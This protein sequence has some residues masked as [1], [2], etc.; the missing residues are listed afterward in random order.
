M[1]NKEYEMNELEWKQHSKYLNVWLRADGKVRRLIY[2]G[3]KR[4]EIVEDYGTPHNGYCE[5]GIPGTTKLECVHRLVADVFIPKT[6]EDIELCRDFINHIDENR[7]NNCVS[8][9]EWCTNQENQ[10]HS[11]HK[12]RGSKCYRARIIERYDLLTGETIQVYHGGYREMVA[13]GFNSSNVYQCCQGKRNKHGGFGW[14]YADN[15]N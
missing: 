14:R 3:T 7:S 11:A 10:L 12:K 5:I 15:N 1:S 4:E 6:K 8:N 9:L 2:E 13:Q